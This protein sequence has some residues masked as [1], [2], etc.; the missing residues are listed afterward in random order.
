MAEFTRSFPD[1]PEL[2]RVVHAFESRSG[3]PAVLNALV[4]GA[5]GDIVLFADA[6]Q[7][8]EPST[9]RALVADF[10][11]PAVGAVSGEL[12]LEPTEGTAAGGT[13]RGGPRRRHILAL[14]ETDS[15][16]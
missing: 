16:R 5:A 11:D 8:F 3:K 2:K 12:M 7:R 9:L 6:R 10:N 14:R 1:D 13:G 15:V 4:P